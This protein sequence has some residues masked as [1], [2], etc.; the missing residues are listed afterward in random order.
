[1]LVSHHLT[2]YYTYY[3]S[4][5]MVTRIQYR[6]FLEAHKSPRPLEQAQVDL[7]EYDGCHNEWYEEQGQ[8][9]PLD[10]QYTDTHGLQEVYPDH[11]LIEALP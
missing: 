1:M 10:Q 8:V 9:E 2:P 4:T 3:D 6:C 11:D 5:H 7:M